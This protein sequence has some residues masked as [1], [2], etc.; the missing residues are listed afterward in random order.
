MSALDLIMELVKEGYYPEI[1]NIQEKIDSNY[2]ISFNRRSLRVFLRQG[3]YAVPVPKGYEWFALSYYGLKKATERTK[4]IVFIS[5]SHKDISFAYQLWKMI[6]NAGIPCYLAELYPE[7]GISLWDK[8]KKMI[9]TSEVV[10][11]LYTHNARFS[12]YVN[13]EIGYAFAKGKLVIPV[14]E[15]GVGLPGALDGIEY[16]KYN[17]KN[18]IDTLKSIAEFIRSFLEKKAKNISNTIALALILG[19]LL[20][21][22]SPKK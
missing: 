4:T 3:N 14:V 17:T 9:E 21:I 18:P 15:E 7:P 5:Y 10:I 2:T 12:A 8:I 1:L 13:Q 20:L 11:A 19:S 22:S 16:I 6:S